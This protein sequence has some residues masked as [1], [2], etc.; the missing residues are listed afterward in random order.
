VSSVLTSA[1]D[2][3][4]GSNQGKEHVKRDLDSINEDESVLGRNE[5]EVDRM[6]DGPDLPRSLAGRQQITLD[7]LANGSERVA[8][9]QSQ[10][11]EE[12]AHENGAPEQLING[13]LQRHMFGLLAFNLTVQPV[14]KVMSTWS[15]V[16]KTK[17][18][19]RNEPFHIKCTSRYE[20]LE[21]ASK[22]NC[23]MSAS[24]VVTYG[25]IQ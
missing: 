24:G 16:N 8:V 2:L 19:E 9:D 22:K 4:F 12:D 20:N 17:D 15:M 25:I 21:M 3:L 6:N 14:V 23:K 11:G 1:K 7:L 13:N 10:I 18:R 5:F